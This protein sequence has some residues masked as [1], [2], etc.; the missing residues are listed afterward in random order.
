MM[1]AIRAQRAGWES[2]GDCQSLNQLPT[3]FDAASNFKVS[4]A[5][6]IAHQNSQDRLTGS[7][8]SIAHA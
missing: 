3:Q 2:V 1:P 5:N 8:V 6:T 4:L 7:V